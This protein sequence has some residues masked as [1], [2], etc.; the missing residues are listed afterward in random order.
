MVWGTLKVLDVHL[1]TDGVFEGTRW[2]LRRWEL[3]WDRAVGSVNPLADLDLE[4]LDWD[5]APG[6]GLLAVDY[7]LRYCVLLELG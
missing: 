2:D 5:C 3:V 7:S 4:P 6:V 1:S